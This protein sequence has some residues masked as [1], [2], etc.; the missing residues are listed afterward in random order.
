MST[1]LQLVNFARGECGV[2]GGDLSTLASVTGESLRFKNWVIRAWEEIQELH[3]DWKWM[4]AAF[5]FTTTA[6]DGSYTSAQAGIASRFGYWDRTYCTVYLT[7]TGVSDQTELRWL[8]YE[9]FRA[10]YLTGN[11]TDSRP[12]HFTVGDS[13]EL[14]IGPAPGSTAYTVAGKYYK[15]TQTLSDDDDE[16]ELPEQHKIIAYKAVMKYAVFDSAPEVMSLGGAEYNR[17][18]SFLRNRYLPAIQL[19]GPLV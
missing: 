12:Q 14:L 10:Y 15:S 7:A 2:S 11:Q 16:P 3:A 9:T 1:F 4:R 18:L 13:N 8:D 19:G 5:S 17:I 6:N